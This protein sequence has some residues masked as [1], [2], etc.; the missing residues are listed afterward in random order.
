MRKLSGT[1]E[2]VVGA[3]WSPTGATL[4]YVA[5][6]EPA[7]GGA[8]HLRVETVCAEGKRL[9]VLA[10]QSAATLIWGSPVWTPDGKRLLVAVERHS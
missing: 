6:T 2:F 5:G 10:R 1:G 4:G 9:H 3:A 7:P 8:A